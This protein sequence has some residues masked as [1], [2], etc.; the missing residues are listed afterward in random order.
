MLVGDSTAEQTMATLRG[1]QPSHQIFF[2]R[3]WLV[4]NPR[5]TDAVDLVD[6][7]VNLL[8]GSTGYTPKTGDLRDFAAPLPYVQDELRLRH[9]IR[10]FDVQMAAVEGLGTT[11]DLIGLQLTLAESESRLDIALARNRVLDA[12]YR[13][14]SLPE[15]AVKC[16]CLA[17]MV[18]ALPRIDH[19]GQIERSEGL[20]LVSQNDL[21]MCIDQLL[22]ETA[23]HD[24]E[25]QNCI[26]TLAEACPSLALELAS[27]LNTQDRRD[28]AHLHLATAALAG[29]PVSADVDLAKKAILSI[30]SSYYRD[31]AYSLVVH[32]LVQLCEGLGEEQIVKSLEILNSLSTVQ[33]P[34]RRCDCCCQGI[35]FVRVAAGGRHSGTADRLRRQFEATWDTID[36]GWSRVDVGFKA[37]RELAKLEPETARRYLA[38]T[39]EL[40][41]SLLIDAAATAWTFRACLELAIKAHKAS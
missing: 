19:E 20:L 4:A 22:A 28:R 13:V 26:R 31:R 27:R 6:Y 29:D 11:E 1:L 30:T 17:L 36:V 23:D 33:D 2:L 40:K 16:D 14:S 18:A 39:D 35:R 3:Q 32:R 34:R 5:R 38:A 41:A 25:T 9:L 8:I 7:A 24:R 15:L 37:A 12:Y 21:R 10:R